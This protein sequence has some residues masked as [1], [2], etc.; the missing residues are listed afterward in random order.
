M[1]ANGRSQL[2]KVCRSTPRSPPAVLITRPCRRAQ[3]IDNDDAIE[4]GVLRA[5]DGDTRLAMSAHHVGA[6]MVWNVM[7]AST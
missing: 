6:A 4:A 1:I 5:A 7:N 2:L 3:R